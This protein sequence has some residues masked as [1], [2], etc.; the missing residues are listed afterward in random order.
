MNKIYL[1]TFLIFLTFLFTVGLYYNY[2]LSLFDNRYFAATLETFFSDHLEQ[3]LFGILLFIFYIPGLV[4]LQSGKKITGW[5][6]SIVVVILGFGI[7]SNIIYPL[8]V[9]YSS[10]RINLFLGLFVCFATLVFIFIMNTIIAISSKE[11]LTRILLSISCL[12]FSFAL[13]SYLF[14]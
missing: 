13:I 1:N 5:G 6:L 4:K 11:N 14:L 9:K 8:I 2:S 12:S 3:L 10:L 7:F